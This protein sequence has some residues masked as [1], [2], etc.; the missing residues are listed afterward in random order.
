MQYSLFREQNVYKDETI[1]G[2]CKRLICLEKLKK[3]KTLAVTGYHKSLISSEE[4][5]KWQN[6]LI[7]KTVFA[8]LPLGFNLY[9]ILNESKVVQF[10]QTVD[11]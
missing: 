4:M 2:H 7:E 8:C 1:L 10:C 5:P 11:L 6:V 3:T 9:R